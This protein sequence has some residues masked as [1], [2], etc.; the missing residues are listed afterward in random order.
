VGFI[1][2]AD[3][4]LDITAADDGI[5]GTTVVQIDGG[6]ININRST[7]GI[8][9]TCI[10]INGGIIDIYATED[11][12][13]ASRKSR[14][15]S[16]LIE[17]NGGDISV[18]VGSGDTDAFDSNGNIVVNGGVI[19]VTATS[20]FDS[21]G[22]STLN[23]GTVTVNGSVV[24]Q[25]TGGMDGRSGPQSFCGPNVGQRKNRGKLSKHC[26]VR[27]PKNSFSRAGR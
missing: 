21:E 14:S 16:L 5:R 25:L 1:Y 11:G 23:G 26:E 24:A 9:A 19:A 12:I 8:E 4:S 20:A 6:T 27:I 17:V 10:Q 3:G 15:Y 7:E 2:I 18:E 13:N 22:T